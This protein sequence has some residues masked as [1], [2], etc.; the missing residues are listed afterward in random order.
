MLI[1]STVLSWLYQAGNTASSGRSVRLHLPESWMDFDFTQLFSEN[2]L[3]SPYFPT[4]F[5]GQPSTPLNTQAQPVHQS[6]QNRQ[7][8]IST[9]PFMTV[10]T[11]KSQ[12]EN[13]Q[14]TKLLH[15]FEELL[16]SL[17]GTSYAFISSSEPHQ[18]PA[19]LNHFSWMRNC[20]SSRL[21]QQQSGFSSG[22][23][24]NK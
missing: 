19:R 5:T 17:I 22:N 12:Q 1:W 8:N 4:G 3:L 6:P 21:P 2:F 14:L 7:G 20:K 13:E 15:S 10:S 24:I 23:A 11:L 18:T 16:I 9:V